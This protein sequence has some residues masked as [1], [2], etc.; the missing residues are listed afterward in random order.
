MT[1]A[2]RHSTAAR[3]REHGTHKQ[4]AGRSNGER[5]ERAHGCR[6]I[7]PREMRGEL[8]MSRAPKAEQRAILSLSNN[9][10]EMLFRSVANLGGRGNRGAK[11]I[12]IT[13]REMERGDNRRGG[14]RRERERAIEGETEG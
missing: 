2:R 11:P 12:V 5:Q 10:R 3:A 6:T 9:K 13:E 4:I 7:L 1:S 8:S 14:D